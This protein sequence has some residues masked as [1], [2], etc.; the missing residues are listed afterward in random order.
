[1][2]KIAEFPEPADG[3]EGRVRGR[4]DPVPGDRDS[5][6]PGPPHPRGVA[7]AAKRLDGR[8]GTNGTSRADIGRGAPHAPQPTAEAN[9]PS[10]VGRANQGTALYDSPPLE[11]LTCMTARPRKRSPSTSDRLLTITA[12]TRRRRS[13]IRCRRGAEAAGLADC[14][15]GRHELPGPIG[16]RVPERSFRPWQG[17]QQLGVPRGGKNRRPRV[18]DRRVLYGEC[19]PL[20]TV[21]NCRPSPAKA[22][23]APLAV[24]C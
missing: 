21:G 12:W 7:T 3:A 1:M 8:P 13:H 15:V 19:G 4:T 10:R 9:S 20:V 22:L 17:R 16:A 5:P 18:I 2:R 23:P 14:G 24:P 6:G 11:G